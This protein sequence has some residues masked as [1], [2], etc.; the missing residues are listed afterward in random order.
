VPADRFVNEGKE[1]TIRA[2]S[3]VTRRV[4]N[5]AKSTVSMIEGSACVPL[6][7][8]ADELKLLILLVEQVIDQAAR[9]VLDAESVAVVLS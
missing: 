4:R 9:R 3:K 2:I 5:Y 1:A 8:L 7:A 6:F